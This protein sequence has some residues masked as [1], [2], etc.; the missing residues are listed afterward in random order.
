[1]EAPDAVSARGFLWD[2][3]FLK[4]ALLQVVLGIEEDVQFGFIILGDAYFH[5]VTD[6]CGIGHGR[7]RS[8]VVVEDLEGDFRRQGQH[9]AAPPPGAEG[10]DGG[11][12]QGLGANGQDGPVGGEV[13]GRGACRRCHQSPIADE[14]VDASFAVDGDA[15]IRRLPSLPKE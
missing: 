4:D 15:Q 1:M 7:D 11:Q 3:L 6:L 5:H 13:I 12:G 8:L 9:R 10:A 14:P 2:E